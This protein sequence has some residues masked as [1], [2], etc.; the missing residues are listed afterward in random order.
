ML[1]F[2]GITIHELSGLCH[3]L[4]RS[5]AFAGGP[6]LDGGRRHVEDR[7]ICLAGD[8][9]DHAGQAPAHAGG[10]LAPRERAL[11]EHELRFDLL[12]DAG[13][14]AH[15]LAEP[16]LAKLIR[17]ASDLLGVKG[18]VNDCCHREVAAEIEGDNPFYAYPV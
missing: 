3:L 15:D 14:I 18:S 16:V 1:V 10:S 6:F 9:L 17:R 7:N 11:V 2:T 5:I 13:H 8:S 12:A 4:L